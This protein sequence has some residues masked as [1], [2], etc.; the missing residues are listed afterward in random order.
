MSLFNYTPTNHVKTSQ[1]SGTIINQNIET[2]ILNEKAG[3]NETKI[4]KTFQK[5]QELFPTITP[6]T[7]THFVSEVNWSNH[8][9]VQHLITL[10][11]PVNMWFT[12]FALSEVAARMLLQLKQSNQLLAIHGL[13]DYRVQNRHPEAYHLAKTLMVKMNQY[14]NHSKVTVLENNNWQIVINSS[15]NYTNNMRVESGIICVNTGVT[16]FYKDWISN[17]IKHG[18]LYE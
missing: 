18:H 9:L 14:P 1:D 12:T 16:N 6:G 15:A 5:L 4:L 10:T 8:E 11:G 7:N 13:V 17:I 2:K 3:I